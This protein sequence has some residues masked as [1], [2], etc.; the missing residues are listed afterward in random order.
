MNSF[1]HGLRTIAISLAIPLLAAETLSAQEY[2]NAGLPWHEAV[3]DPQGRLLAWYHPEKN[4]GYDK[5]LRL[6]WDFLEHRVPDQGNTGLKVYLVSSV[7]DGDTLQGPRLGWQHDPAGLYAH[8]VDLLLGWYGYSGDSE[9]VPVVQSMLDYQL[10]HG[11]TPGNW[12]WASVPYATSCDNALEY[13]GCFGI[14][15]ETARILPALSSPTQ[16]SSTGTIRLVSSPTKW[17]NWAWG[18][19]CSTR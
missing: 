15:A 3:L 4:L 9:A 2:V 6:D 10:A 8:M 1:K 17:V 11:T 7:F 5:F 12:E 19:C 16:A 13:G 18:T 14:T